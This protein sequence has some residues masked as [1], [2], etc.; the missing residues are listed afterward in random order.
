MATSHDICTTPKVASVVNVPTYAWS[1]HSGEGMARASLD[2]D[3]ALEDDFQTQ[4]TPVCHI[5]QWEDDGHRSS[6]EGRL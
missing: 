1:I 2:Q 5:M 3:E 4:H 6:A